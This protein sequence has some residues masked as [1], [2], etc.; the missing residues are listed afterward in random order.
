MILAAVE[1][2][3]FVQA[4]KVAIDARAQEASAGKFLKF[5]SVFAFAAADDGSE[6]HDAF[7]GLKGEDKLHNLLGGLARNE[8]AAMGAVRRADGAVNDAQVV[9]D[10]GDGADG[11]TGRARGGFLLNG[12]RGRKA[13]DRVDF[14]ALH[15]VEELPRVGGKRFDIAALALGVKRVERERGFA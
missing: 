13:F 7:V 5:L 2:G 3:R 6:D 10:F 4:D 14:R 11:R 8:F 12:N 15:L 9:V 1:R